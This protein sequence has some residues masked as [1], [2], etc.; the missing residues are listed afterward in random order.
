[1]EFYFKSPDGTML[2]AVEEGEGGNLTSEDLEGGYVDY[3]NTYLYNIQEKTELDGGMWLEERPIYCEYNY[4]PKGICKLIERMKECDAPEDL[5]EWTLLEHD[6]GLGIVDIIN[7]AIMERIEKEQ[8]Y[9]GKT[10]EEALRI[11]LDEI[12]QEEEHEISEAAHWNARASARAELYKDI[13][14][15]IE[16]ILEYG[17]NIH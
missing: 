1:M 6:L 17:Q 14:E 2:Y 11:L 13:R 8:K 3:W 5:E 15:R 12:K 10:T 16:R 4:S 7:E 9:Y